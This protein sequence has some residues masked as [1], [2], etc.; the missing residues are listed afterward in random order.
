MANVVIKMV[1]R[2]W[3]RLENAGVR[4]C[5]VL[6]AQLVDIDEVIWRGCGVSYCI[7]M[8]FNEFGMLARRNRCPDPSMT[9]Q[10]STRGV[11]LRLIWWLAAHDLSSVL[12]PIGC[13][14]FLSSCAFR[15]SSITATRNLTSEDLSS[16]QRTK[17]RR[18]GHTIVM[19]TWWREKMG[20]PPLRRFLP[21]AR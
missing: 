15:E 12:K 17:H 3:A 7:L 11:G 9:T 8:S 10:I 18:S 21:V 14:Y 20:A 16:W 6:I 19:N 1:I 5:T 2:R 4:L 13:D